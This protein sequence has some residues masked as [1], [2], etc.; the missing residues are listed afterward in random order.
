MLKPLTIAAVAA[1]AIAAFD[2]APAN[3]A[4]GLNNGSSLQGASFDG[5]WENGG[6]FQGI[7]R[8]GIWE[9]GAAFQGI[10]RNGVWQ[11]GSTLQG[12]DLNGSGYQG[13]S[14]NGSN[15]ALDGQVVGIELPAP[16]G[17]AQ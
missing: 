4:A 5:I 3:A 17:A 10:T 15:A 13:V 11:N 16:V 8:N 12:K 14:F 2:L 1:I 6:A 9:N 7:T